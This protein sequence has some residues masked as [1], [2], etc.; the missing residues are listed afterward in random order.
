MGSRALSS[1]RVTFGEP[2]DETRTF[3]FAVKIEVLV[4]RRAGASC[5][6]ASVRDIWGRDRPPSDSWPDPPYPRTDRPV[7]GK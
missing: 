2:S 5:F 1:N 6:G 4:R 7:A 3:G